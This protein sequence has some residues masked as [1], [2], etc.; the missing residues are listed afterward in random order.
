MLS[1]KLSNRSLLANFRTQSPQ[2][3]DDGNSQG[4]SSR[5]LPP[6]L[7]RKA[8]NQQH[9]VRHAFAFT[10]WAAVV[11]VCAWTIYFASSHEGDT[12]DGC[13]YAFETPTQKMFGI[14]IRLGG[15]L[16]YEQA[17]AIDVAWDLVLGQGGRVLQAY[18]L[19]R[20]ALDALTCLMER[21]A[22][23]FHLYANV[24]LSWPT[25][26]DGFWSIARVVFRR[27]RWQ[28]GIVTAWLLLSTIHVFGFVLLWE[29]ATGYINP[30][31]QY[32]QLNN[33]ALIKQT[34]S[35]LESCIYSTP[36]FSTVCSSRFLLTRE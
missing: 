30:S 24:S 16:S 29:S 13:G 8:S 21:S 20:V 4:Y 22:V 11:A 28:S 7:L 23:P 9:I 1:P 12:A 32:Y 31:R 2:P 18:L 5:V 35:N 33:G 10:A 17:K 15:T 27:H 6:K 19:Y 3:A 25:S 34:S 14:N 36:S 26:W